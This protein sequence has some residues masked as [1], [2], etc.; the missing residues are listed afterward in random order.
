MASEV[1]EAHG[2]AQSSPPGSFNASLK[3]A[4]EVAKVS[5]ESP[6]RRRSGGWDSLPSGP[7]LK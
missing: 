2:S 1:D 4:T 6:E 3:A 5:W 7:A